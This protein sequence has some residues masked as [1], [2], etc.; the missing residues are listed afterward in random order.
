MKLRKIIAVPDIQAPQH[1]PTAVT[2]ALRIIK[3]EKPDEIVHIGDLIAFDSISRFPKRDREE[4]RLTADKE[5]AVANKILDRFDKA[6]DGRAKVVY[7]EGNHERRLETF[8]I[9][10]ALALGE[11]FRGLTIQE[12]LHIDE[13]GYKY[14]KTHEQ[15]Y[16]VGELGFIHGW[17]CNLYHAAKHV[18]QGG[19]NLIYGHTHDHQT[20]TGAHLDHQEPRMAMSIGCLCDFRQAYLESRPSN[21]IHGVAIIYVDEATGLFW[22]HFVPIIN[23][24]AVINGKKYSA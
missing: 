12:Q 8:I 14:V 21:W 11:G 9:Q 13:R 16:V 6:T 3:G 17:Y 20:Y 18:R 15:P 1:D 7:L 4:A 19:R 22:P 2:T 10:N 23:G 24:V 5:I